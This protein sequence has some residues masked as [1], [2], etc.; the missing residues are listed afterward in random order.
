MLSEN[1]M[2]AYALETPVAL[3]RYIPELLADLEDLGSDAG[4]I[5]S[6]LR[7]LGP[8]ESATVV[9]LGCGKGAVAIGIA[10]ELE[11]RVVGIDLFE[12]FIEHC[13]ARAVSRGVSGL[14]RFIHGNILDRPARLG[15]FDI[16]IF[17]SLGDVL[18]PL[19]ESIDVV[20]QYVRPGGH[21]VISDGFIKSGGSS[22]FP[23]FE[24]YADR[25]T[26]RARLTACGD[27]LVQEV[28]DADAFGAGEGE[29]IA[30][31]AKAI[32]LRS[33]EIAA[34]VLAYARMQ[35][36]E[37]EFLARNFASAIWVLKRAR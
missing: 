18:G 9:D 10:K 1:E 26:M 37:Y 14:C 17:A 31:R 12:P 36:A 6:V 7:D 13:E 16:A 28:I 22:D 2:V 29:L 32:A 20:R 25:D 15:P 30:A 35:V 24:P 21:I 19:D 33:P 23:G 3:L 4:A 34:D 11:L 5:V 27:T 8:A